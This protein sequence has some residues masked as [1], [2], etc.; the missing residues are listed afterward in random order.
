M[1]EDVGLCASQ[2]EST[3]VVLPS[4]TGPNGGG[5]K[6]NK[7]K[8]VC[9]SLYLNT[10]RDLK[11]SDCFVTDVFISCFPCQRPQQRF[12]VINVLQAMQGDR[13]M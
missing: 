8:H 13:F 12:R 3:H 9:L 5:W 6:K 1:L 11:Q 2:Q 4:R 10:G 7:K